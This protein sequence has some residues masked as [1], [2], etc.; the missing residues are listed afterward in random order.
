MNIEKQML[1][2]KV[3]MGQA[4]EEEMGGMGFDSVVAL[5]SDAERLQFRDYAPLPDV[6]M[7][8]VGDR[9]FRYTFSSEAPDRVGDILKVDG[10]VLKDFRR[11]PVA[12]WS[13]DGRTR[14]PVGVARNLSTKGMA[15]NFRSLEGDIEIAPEG[16]SVFTDELNRFVD[17]GIVKATSVG[18]RILKTQPVQDKDEREG[19]GLG[20]FG[21]LSTKHSLLEISLVAVPMHQDAIRRSVDEMLTKGL[22][23]KAGSDE[24][25]SAILKPEEYQ[26]TSNALGL[27]KGFVP[28]EWVPTMTKM[29][30]EPKE[31]KAEEDDAMEKVLA[32]LDRLE[33]RDKKQEAAI[34][35]IHVLVSSLAEKDSNSE[36]ADGHAGIPGDASNKADGSDAE[37][38]IAQATALSVALAGIASEVD[39]RL[40]EGRT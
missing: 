14:P 24:V 33:Q 19:L 20:P 18:V 5:K 6:E 29:L 26:E 11:N 13:H 23:T 12:L 15:G 27:L 4:T 37:E 31:P 39:T 3:L 32:S 30:A 35:E 9:T 7:K 38:D 10:W 16:T 28:V 1:E 40:K 34:G 17:A 25:L 2:A 36:Q 21:I 8:R 22:V